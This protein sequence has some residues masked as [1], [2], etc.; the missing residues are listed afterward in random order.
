MINKYPI[1]EVETID[2]A[3]DQTHKGHY[4][5]GGFYNSSV[6]DTTS[7]EL[8]I[9]NG[10]VSTFHMKLGVVA[11][12][13]STVQI[14]EG[15]TF[16]GAGT[17]VTMTNHNR[18]SVTAFSGTVTHTPTLTLDGTQITATGFIPGGTKHTGGGG[19]F[20]FSNELILAKSTN[21][22]I[23]VTNVSGSAMKASLSVE[24]YQPS[25]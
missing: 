14:F 13:N 19:D 15:T 11:S 17:T 23:R 8:L 12:G 20:G 25:L 2:H 3:H 24:G 4:F 1:G 10:S 18:V 5:S 16:S 7:M 9:Q 6:A 21:Y 22:L